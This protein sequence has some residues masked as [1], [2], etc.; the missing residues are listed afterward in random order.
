[1]CNF[2]FWR[3][4]SVS[5]ASEWVAIAWSKVLFRN[6]T[7]LILWDDRY[8]RISVAQWSAQQIP[9]AKVPVRAPGGQSVHT[10]FLMILWTSCERPIIGEVECQVRSHAVL[11]VFQSRR[12]CVGVSHRTACMSD[13]SLIYP[14]DDIN[15][16]TLCQSKN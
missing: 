8:C 12:K 16:I 5:C 4:G 11:A 15:E 14:L 2:V 1:M 6:Y 10:T 13:F 3:A 9:T 7:F